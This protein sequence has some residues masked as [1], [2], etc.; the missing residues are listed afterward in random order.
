MLY[1]FVFVSWGGALIGQDDEGI[2]SI[3]L[4]EG[5]TPCPPEGWRLMPSELANAVEQLQAYFA[6]ELSRFD[7][8]LAPEGTAFQRTVWR[9][10]TEIPYGQTISYGQLAASIG[11]PSACRAVGG[12]NGKNPIPVVIPCHRVIGSDGS[13]T[14]FSSGLSLKR[15]LLAIEGVNLGGW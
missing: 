11:R 3:R 1:D 14:G 12:A 13:L 10:L 15:R 8:P 6:G 4:F 2:R 7:L 9:A 5:T